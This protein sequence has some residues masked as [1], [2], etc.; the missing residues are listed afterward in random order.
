MLPTVYHSCQDNLN[1]LLL[2]LMQC[3]II[4]YFS[5]L[6]LPIQSSVLVALKPSDSFNCTVAW[7]IEFK[8]LLLQKVQLPKLLHPSEY[9]QSPSRQVPSLAAIF[10]TPFG[11]LFGFNKT[12]ALSKWMGRELDLHFPRS[13]GHKKHM[14]EIMMKNR[15]KSLKGFGSFVSN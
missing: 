4:K 11:Q 8:L 7:W 13:N 14:F 3:A 6:N 2:L 12:R 5:T 9:I 10:E 1:T 15:L